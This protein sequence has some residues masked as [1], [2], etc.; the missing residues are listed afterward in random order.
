M[1]V[2]P[3]RRSMGRAGLGLVGALL[4]ASIASTVV[5]GRGGD[6]LPDDAVAKVGDAVITKADFVRQ[7]ERTDVPVMQA[8]KV[9]L[10][11]PDFSECV[12]IVRDQAPEDTPPDALRR[13]CSGQFDQLKGRVMPALLA[14]EW[15]AQEARRRGISVEGPAVIQSLRS[16]LEGNTK[17][18]DLR[19]YLRDP[20]RG[21]GSLYNAVRADLLEVQLGETVTQ[22]ARS[23]TDADVERYFERR[24]D[25]LVVPERRDVR[26]VLTRTM[27]HANAAKTALEGGRRWAAVAK[28]H[29][30]DP[31]SKAHGG[32]IAG[33]ESGELEKGLDAAVFRSITGRVEGP[34]STQFGWYVFEVT[35]VRRPTRQSLDEARRKI[36]DRLRSESRARVLDSLERDMNERYEPKTVCADEYK[37]PVCGNG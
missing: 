5:A 28:E 25:G 37:I 15:I 27:P 35:A 17:P 13:N 2:L 6:G 29:S 3:A 8:L 19:R 23:V 21:R 34:L 14:D 11:P 36:R 9:A 10:Q 18:S 32:R 16:S 7:A 4:A 24:K 31:A 1:R 20:E 33:V 26:V 12:A 30:I 22:R